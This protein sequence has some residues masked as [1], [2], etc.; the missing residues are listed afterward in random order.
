M[1]LPKPLK[2]GIVSK[3]HISDHYFRGTWEIQYKEDIPNV[4]LWIYDFCHK[5]NG[6]VVRVNY[7]LH[8]QPWTCISV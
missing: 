2:Q 1:V 8:H 3:F 5:I 4:E 7:L 6:T